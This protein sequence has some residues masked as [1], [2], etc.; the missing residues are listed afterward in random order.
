MESI[1]PNNHVCDFGYHVCVVIVGI[2]TLLS[3]MHGFN[4]GIAQFLV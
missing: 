2:A 3:A 4:T 1:A